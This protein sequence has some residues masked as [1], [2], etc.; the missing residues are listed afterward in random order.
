MELTP[1][2]TSMGDLKLVE[3]VGFAGIYLLLS[4]VILGLMKKVAQT[5]TI[6]I[7]VVVLCSSDNFKYVCMASI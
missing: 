3:H 7:S 4:L 1:W 6:M 5:S 2:I